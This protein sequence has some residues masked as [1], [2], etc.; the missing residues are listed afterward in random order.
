MALG[1]EILCALADYVYIHSIFLFLNPI[2]TNVLVSNIYNTSGHYKAFIK[3]L[4]YL[5]DTPKPVAVSVLP[6]FLRWQFST[7]HKKKPWQ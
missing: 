2:L 1:K 7:R 6:L 3:L 4:A 5:D